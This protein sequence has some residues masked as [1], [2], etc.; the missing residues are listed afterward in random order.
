MKILVTGGTGFIGGHLLN[1]LPTKA[2]EIY[3]VVRDP[4]KLA[5]ATMPSHRIKIIQGNLT[6]R[7]TYSKFPEPIDIVI[8]LAASLGKWD[9]EESHII[10]NNVTVT[11][12]LLKWFKKGNGKQF[13]FISTPGVQGLGYKLAEEAAPYRPRGLYEISKAAAE[14]KVINYSYHPGQF[15]TILRPDFVYG[16]GDRRRIKLYRKIKNRHWLKIGIGKSVLRPTFVEDVAHAICGCL[17]QK[18]A[19]DQIFNV[20]GP[21]LISADDYANTI[22][23]IFNVKIPPLRIPACI[24]EF[25]GALFESGARIMGTQPF[26]T[27]SQVEF[28]TQ[29]HGTDTSKIRQYLGFSPQVCFEQG[30]RR[31]LTWAC[32]N[33]LL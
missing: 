12:L 9:I 33:K 1:F 17:D 31:T 21:E 22:A 3:C 25:A 28:L 6:D 29:D 27:R 16:P 4:S 7:S 26:M 15:W 24:L 8:H 2:K 13:I 20:A 32:K 30:M 10:E 23:K 5:S 19:R 11:E 18:N 14:K